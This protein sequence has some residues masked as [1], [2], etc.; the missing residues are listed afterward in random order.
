MVRE[1]H[2]LASSTVTMAAEQLLFSSVLYVCV[3]YVYPL[4]VSCVYDSSIFYCQQVES[5]LNI[6]GDHYFLLDALHVYLL[7]AEVRSVDSCIL[8][9]SFQF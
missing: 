4:Y 8:C 9:I 1:R 7:S 2:N 3:Y 5:L 6:K